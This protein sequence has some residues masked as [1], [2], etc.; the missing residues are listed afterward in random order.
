MS[1]YDFEDR[2]MKLEQVKDLLSVYIGF[3]TEENPAQR[4][5]KKELVE[6]VAYAEREKIYMCV[7][8]CAFDIVASVCED[9][10]EH[11]ENACAEARASKAAKA[12]KE[13]VA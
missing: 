5:D 13:D 9:L 8:D 2:M 10:R 12:N 6:A 3:S 7:L 4:L 11:V 1:T